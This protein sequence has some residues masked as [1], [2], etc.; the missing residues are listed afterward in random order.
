[1]KINVYSEW[2]ERAI[3]GGRVQTLHDQVLAHT[4]SP[5]VMQKKKIMAEI[6]SR[7]QTM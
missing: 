4:V 2:P 3:P 6:E 5:N 1:M 7:G